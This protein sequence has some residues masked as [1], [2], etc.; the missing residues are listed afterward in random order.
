MLTADLSKLLTLR[1]LRVIATLAD[2]KLVARVAEAL[3]L[4]QPAIS[5]QIAEL[6]RLVGTPLVT[7]ERNRLFL[8]PIG[9]RLAVHAQQVLSQLDRAAF[10]IEAMAT[11]ITGSVSIGVVSSVAP[12]LLPAALTLFKRGAP[13]ASVTITEGHFTALYPQFEAGQIDLLI[14][15]TW[16]P[17]ELP[18]V[19]QS[20]LMRDAVVVVAGRDHPLGLRDSLQWADV[21]DWPWLLPQST[22]VARNA[23]EAYFAQLGLPLPTNT[24]ASVS[25][26][27]NLALMRD[28]PVLGLFPKS[29]AQTHVAR[30]DIVVL[31]LETD[32]LL[33]EARS[34]WHARGAETNNTLAL[35]LRC[36]DQA[37]AERK[38]M[39]NG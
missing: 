34:F 10:D 23:V 24:I 28:M 32:G 3:N 27:L 39:P 33:S 5:K 4:S 13:T 12:I 17:Q 21:T 16:Q 31:P 15:R 11:G 14:A 37:A 18:G 38:T 25:L 6:E 22:S 2:L 36:L 20:V 30:G 29:L 19:R 8:T 35:F 7:R 26:P 1:H 9:A